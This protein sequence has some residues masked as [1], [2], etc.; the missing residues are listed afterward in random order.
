MMTRG[1]DTPESRAFI[2]REF[3]DLVG[4]T[5]T[6][7]RILTDEDMEACGWKSGLGDVAFE[8]VLDDGRSLCP[9]QDTEGNGPGFVFIN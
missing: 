1:N 5:I 3:G 6:D 8:F 4:R 7:V 9:S 2:Q